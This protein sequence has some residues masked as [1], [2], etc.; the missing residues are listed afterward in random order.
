[1][2]MLSPFAHAVDIL[3][4]NDNKQSTYAVNLVSHVGNTWTYSVAQVKGRTLSHWVLGINNCLN[5]VVSS[6]P[7]ADEIG[8]DPSTAARFVG[9]KWNS[10]G[11]TFSFTL[12]KDYESTTLQALVKTSTVYNT[13]NIEGPDCSKPVGA[14]APVTTE[15]TPPATTEPTPPVT[16]EPTP[17]VAI[18]PTPPVTIEPTPPVTTEPTPPATTE[19]TPPATTEPTPPAT[20]E[21]TPPVTTEPTTA[22]GPSDSCAAKSKTPKSTNASWVDSKG[23]NAYDIELVSVSGRT[24]TYRVTKTSGKALSHWTLGIPACMSK[25]VSSTSTDGSAAEIGKDASIKDINFSGI[26]WNSEGGVFSFTLDNDYATTAVDVLAKAGSLQDGGYSTSTIMGPDC[27]ALATTC[28]DKPLSGEQDVV[29]VHVWK[30]VT[31]TP[32]SPE[33]YQALDKNGVESGVYAIEKIDASG[34]T[35]DIEVEVVK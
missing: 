15:P 24:W 3:I 7:K 1:M 35:V 32:I 2:A 25:I 31:A 12:D 10:A 20:T 16:T 22:S 14:T 26:K 21:P 34:K 27:S 29:A 6:S 28:A 33:A 4:P 11:G 8:V 5:N 19:P 23:T 9:I 17:P 18:E 13:G 30:R